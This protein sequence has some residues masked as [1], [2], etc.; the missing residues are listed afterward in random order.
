[1]LGSGCGQCELLKLKIHFFSEVIIQLGCFLHEPGLSALTA[2]DNTQFC[3]TVLHRLSRVIG[4]C[5]GLGPKA[6]LFC[7][8]LWWMVTG[9][10]IL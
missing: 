3:G 6:W 10:Y 8:C 4:A 1:M 9:A 2:G 7:T 5:C